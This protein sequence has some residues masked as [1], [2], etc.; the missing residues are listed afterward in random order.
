MSGFD[1]YFKLKRMEGALRWIRDRGGVID[2]SDPNTML[3]SYPKSAV[4]TS[5]AVFTGSM[6]LIDAFGIA[7]ER[8]EFFQC[9]KPKVTP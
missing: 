7:L 3:I 2:F 1:E 9:E 4:A 8:P 5:Y 6:E